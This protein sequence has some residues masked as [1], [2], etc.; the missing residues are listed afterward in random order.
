M[1]TVIQATNVELDAATRRALDS[2]LLRSLNR[3]VKE[4]DL[5]T[6]YISETDAHLPYCRIAVTTLTHKRLST[7]SGGLTHLAALDQAGSQMAVALQREH[8]RRTDPRLNRS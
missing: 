3:F 7:E 2:Q 1:R 5:A 6:G 4:I 8:M